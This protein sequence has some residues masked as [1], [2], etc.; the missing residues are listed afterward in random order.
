MQHLSSIELNPIVDYS[1][2]DES[3]NIEDILTKKTH[4]QLTLAKLFA[5]LRTWTQIAH[6]H[7]LKLI[8]LVC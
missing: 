8:L 6:K 3:I 5:L 2:F 7:F 1:S 4:H